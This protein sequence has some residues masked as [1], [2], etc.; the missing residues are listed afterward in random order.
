MARLAIF[1]HFRLSFNLC[2]GA[3]PKL[4]SKGEMQKGNDGTTIETLTIEDR[5][6]KAHP[7]S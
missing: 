5:Q 2:K 4:C 3:T 1:T 6:L 7:F